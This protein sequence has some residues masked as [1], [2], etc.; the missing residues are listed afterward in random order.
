MSD[1]KL[2][3]AARVVTQDGGDTEALLLF[4][5][6]V[7]AAG[8]TSE[9]RQHAASAECWEYPGATIVPGFNDAHQHL[10]MTAAQM[11]ALDLSADRVGTPTALAEAISEYS[12]SLPVDAWIIGS[13]YD[14]TRTSGG[15]RTMAL[16]IATRCC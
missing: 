16:A 12:G 8:P 11:T 14:H 2:V 13:R 15:R 10:T 1:L 3:T 9:L 5:D 6:R 4:G 7:M